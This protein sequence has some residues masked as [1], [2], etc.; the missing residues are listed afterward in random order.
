MP[1][2]DTKMSIR[3]DKGVRA[4]RGGN[5]TGVQLDASVVVPGRGSLLFDSIQMTVADNDRYEPEQVILMRSSSPVASNSVTGKVS[6]WVLPVHS[7]EQ[8][9]DDKTPWEWNASE[10]GEDVLKQSQSLKLTYQPSDTPGN[11]MHGFKFQAPVGRFVL[12]EVKAGVDGIGGYVSTKS[13]TSVFRIQPYP[14]ALTFLGQG[15]LLS[16]NGDRKVGFLARGVNRVEIEVGRV[17]P[18]QVQHL[19]ETMWTYEKPNVWDGLGDKILE[20]WT[21]SRDYHRQDSGKPTWDSLD[22][23]PYLQAGSGGTRGLFLLRIR[24]APQNRGSVTNAQDNGDDNGGSDGD[25]GQ[26]YDGQIQDNRLILVTDLGLIVKANKDESREVYVQSIRSGTPIEGA[27]VELLGANGEPVITASTDATGRA[28]FPKFS[29]DWRR[30]KLPQVI[31]VERGSDFS[32]L[33]LR[34]NGRGLDFSRFDIGGAINA[35]SA[36]ELSAYLF[37][38]R[39]IYRPGET[40]HLGAVIRTGD[41]AASLAGLPLKIEISDSLGVV[42]NRQELKLSPAAFESVDWTCAADAPTGTY[43]A[44]AYLVKTQNK[45]ELLGSTSFRVQEFEPDRMKIRLDLTAKTGVAWLRPSDVKP[46]V[47]VTL[48]TGDPAAGRRAEGEVT[49]TPV[50]PSFPK[51]PDHRFQVA[52]FRSQPYREDLAAQTTDQQGNAAFPLDLTRFAGRAY[53]LSI[54]ARAYEA[55]GGRNVAAQNSAIVSDSPWLVGVKPDGDTSFVR[56]NSARSANWL[57]VNQSLDPVAVDGLTLEWVQRK[58][59]SVLTEQNN[60]TYQYVSRLKEIVRDSRKVSIARGGSN[61]ALRTAEP[62]DFVLVLRDSSGAEVNRLSYSVAGDA[63]LSRSLERNAELEI[64]LN[65]K[66]YSAGET[67]DVSLRA[68]YIGAGLITIERDR[69]YAHQWFKTTTASSIQHI[70]VPA[71]FE[72]GGYVTVQYARDP[73]SDDIF[74]SPLSYGVAS[75]SGNLTAR[76]LPLTLNAPKEVKPGVT[77]TMRVTPG[78]AARVGVL[79]VDEGI[80]QVAR[81]RNPDPIGFFFQKKMLEVGTTQI[82][83]LVL[84]EFKRFLAMAAPGGDA[85]GGYARHLNPFQRKR[86]APVAW[87]SGIVD[88][89][90]TGKDF[91]YTIPDYFNGHLRIV[92]IAV[93]PAR[94]GV[95]QTGTDVKGDFVLTPNVPAMVGPGDEFTVSTGVLDNVPGGKGPIHIEAHT[96]AELTPLGPSGIDIDPAGKKEVTAEFRLRA[97]ATPGSASIQISARRGSATSKTEET[98]SV[99]PPTPYRTQLTLGRLDSSHAQVP[100]ARNM[101]SQERNVS[102]AISAVPLVWGQGLLVWLENYP[103]LCTEQLAS[104]GFAALMLTSH[105]ELGT[106]RNGSGQP[107]VNTISTLGGRQNESGGLGLWASVPETAEFPTL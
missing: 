102:A 16:L 37:T 31:L 77:L 1:R 91:R 56:R 98:T 93:S 97:N 92:G 26:P 85:D 70:R 55:G 83:D 30:E 95:V 86:K 25:G 68:P 89:P 39:G 28:A 66:E 107:V 72:G 49:L 36:Q 64:Q 10:T 38:D 29:N 65:K 87:W 21:I 18:N 78:S 14:K 75:F 53:R 11:L 106:L 52:E 81:Y 74:L 104:K 4:A 46:S 5:E 57:A 41:W 48:L 24:E 3:I 71:D 22:L 67:I 27:K 51:Y 105:P 80:L 19:A 88:V 50:F 73:S 79:A 96:G 69:V 59:V 9:K 45:D 47:A 7:T 17:L 34:S 35:K 58:Y 100:L 8:Q 23:T 103:Y 33:P 84:P 32:F 61:I 101:Y 76:T 99:R 13:F 15:A 2:D 54:L 44:L 20:R 6:A 82:L 42:V 62:G 94:I 40:A 43:Q 63:N 60:R 12:V 90:A